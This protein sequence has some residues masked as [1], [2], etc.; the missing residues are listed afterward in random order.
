MLL[1]IQNVCLNKYKETIYLGTGLFKF[2]KYTFKKKENSI[3]KASIPRGV[4]I[5][6]SYW[7]L[8]IVFFFLL[9][10]LGVSPKSGMAGGGAGWPGQGARFLHNTSALHRYYFQSRSRHNT[11]VAKLTPEDIKKAREA[12]QALAKPVK[13]KVGL[14]TPVCK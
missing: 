5:S 8:S 9:S 14:R 6:A 2:N 13:Q 3:L 12:K 1:F 4:Y 10:A 11:V 7:P